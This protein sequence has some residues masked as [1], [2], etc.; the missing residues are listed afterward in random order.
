MEWI[1]L[2]IALAIFVMSCVG[3]GYIAGCQARGRKWLIALSSV[4][5]G[6]L[7]PVFLIAYVIYTGNRYTQPTPAK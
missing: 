7:W 1:P 6:C 4:A 3:L 2:A 5:I